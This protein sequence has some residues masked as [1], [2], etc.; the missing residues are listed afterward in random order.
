MDPGESVDLPVRALAE[1]A[2]LPLGRFLDFAAYVALG[3]F[4]LELG[5]VGLEFLR[6]RLNVGVAARLDLLALHVDLRFQG[7]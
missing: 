7:G 2:H 3:A 5:E 4:R 6:S 1:L